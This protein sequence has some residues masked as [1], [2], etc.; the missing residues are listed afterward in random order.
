MVEDRGMCWAI[1]HQVSSNP[2]MIIEIHQA[3]KRINSRLVQAI[4]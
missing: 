2:A 3:V 4:S 1:R